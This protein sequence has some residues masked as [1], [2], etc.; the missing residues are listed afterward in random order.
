MELEFAHHID[1]L[2][3]FDLANRGIAHLSRAA[4]AHTGEPLTLAAHSG[5]RSYRKVP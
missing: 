2:V 3:N 4:R 1:E 5:L